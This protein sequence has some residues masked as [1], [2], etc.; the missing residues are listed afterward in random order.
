MGVRNYARISLGC[1]YLKYGLQS[2]LDSAPAALR[3]CSRL[4]MGDEAIPS[5]RRVL[6]IQSH[7]VHGY[8]GN[9][10][11]VFPLQVIAVLRGVITFTCQDLSS[12]PVQVLG[13]DVD[14]IN[15]VQFS[16]HTSKHISLS[17]RDKDSYLCPWASVH[18]LHC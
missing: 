2:I 14:A 6:S 4:S 8:V 17:G 15:S 12:P 7:V 5:G 3:A 18:T 1:A 13:C 10:A 11:A 9:N 16:N